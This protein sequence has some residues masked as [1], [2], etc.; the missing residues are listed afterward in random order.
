MQLSDIRQSRDER[1]HDV[2]H[3]VGSNPQKRVEQTSTVKEKNAYHPDSVLCD[4][5]LTEGKA[6]WIIMHKMTT[7]R[8]SQLDD[9]TA[10]RRRSAFSHCRPGE[11][12]TTAG[13][14]VAD[15]GSEECA[16]AATHAQDKTLSSHTV[17]ST[18][19]LR[20]SQ[21]LRGSSKFAPT[22]GRRGNEQ[23]QSVCCS[24]TGGK[25]G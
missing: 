2:S 21:D 16:R 12:P 19:E 1:T 9:E 18:D 3:A 11:A 14:E 20:R 22:T 5:R 15:L 24:Q 4:A 25:K 23:K 17:T 10:E 6:S 7:T 8:S 13:A